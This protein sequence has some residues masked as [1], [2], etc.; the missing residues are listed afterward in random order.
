MHG[1]GMLKSE[2]GVY[3]G[4]FIN[5]MICGT[6]RYDFSDGKIYVGQFVDNC[7]HGQVLPTWPW[8]HPRPLWLSVLLFAHILC[9]ITIHILYRHGGVVNSECF[10]TFFKQGILGYDDQT[11]YEGDFYQGTRHGNGTI[12]FA[13][14]DVYEGGWNKGTRTGDDGEST[15]GIYVAHQGKEVYQG[16]FWNNYRHGDG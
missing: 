10:V 11:V 9:T 6:G 1:Q 4:E 8:K 7:F 14:G 16:G 15:I 2:S 3:S 12:V 13:N 5:H